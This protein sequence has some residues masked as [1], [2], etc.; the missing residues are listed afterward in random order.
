MVFSTLR[1]TNQHAA[2]ELIEAYIKYIPINEMK[3]S[4]Q[5][6]FPNF[7]HAYV[8]VSIYYESPLGRHTVFCCCT[9]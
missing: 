9:N 1:E 6:K 3:Y 4:I 2:D 7:L 5:S 8:I